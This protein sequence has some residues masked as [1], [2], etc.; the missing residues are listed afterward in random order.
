M[1]P[2]KAGILY[3][4]LVF[5]AGWV[6]GPLREFWLIPLVGQRAGLLT[7]VPFMVLAMIAAAR[8]TIRKL[9]VPNAITARGI[10]GVVALGLLL[11]AEAMGVRWA[12]RLSWEA[13]LAR[14]DFITGSITVLSVLL[15]AA[16]PMLVKRR[17]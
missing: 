4:L 6:L 5:A 3:F 7:E 2:I 15:Y 10:M 11:I 16:M 17:A 12:R 1:N 8:W 9:G 14:F 13:Y